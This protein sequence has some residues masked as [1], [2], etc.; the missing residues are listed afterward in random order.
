MK[1]ALLSVFLAFALLLSACSPR[2]V[3]QASKPD[4]GPAIT[5]DPLAT[6]GLPTAVPSAATPATSE[7]MMLTDQQGSV[8]VEVTP[9]DLN[10]PGQS[11]DF[12]V[13]MNTHM[14]DL[15]MDL[16]TLATLATDTGNSAQ[17][18][19]WDG[20]KGGHHVSGKL[21]FPAT[22]NGKPLLEGAKQLTLTIKDVDA[23]TRLFTWDLSK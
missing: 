16:A 1:P 21:I 14:V 20:P 6:A 23:P 9:L 10:Q 4:T 5:A 3:L 12:Q 22:V 15:S 19:S 7:G 2:T 18:L 13:S 8:T 11:L 17:A